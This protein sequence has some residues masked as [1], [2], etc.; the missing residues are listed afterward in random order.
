MGPDEIGSQPDAAGA[1][2]TFLLLKKFASNNRDI[3]INKKQNTMKTNQFPRMHVSLYVTDIAASV[4][5]YNSFFGQSPV[6][7]KSDYAKYILDKPSLIISFVQN[8]Q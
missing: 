3:T 6:K 8:P 7:V 5:F 2:Q 4:Q 1:D